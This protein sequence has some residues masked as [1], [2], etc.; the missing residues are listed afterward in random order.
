MELNVCPLACFYFGC[1]SQ[2]INS[3]WTPG[4]PPFHIKTA[5]RNLRS[6]M[7]LLEICYLDHCLG[8]L[9]ILSNLFL[10]FIFIYRLVFS[11]LCLLITYFLLIIPNIYYRSICKWSCCVVDIFSDCCWYSYIFIQRY[12]YFLPLT[13]M[14]VYHFILF[15]RIMWWY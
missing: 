6:F 14:I 5:G 7:L 10:P 13:T 1:C 2:V 9:F 4:T 8:I 11:T 3:L 15:F 12:Y